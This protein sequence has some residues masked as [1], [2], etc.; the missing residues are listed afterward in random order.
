MSNQKVLNVGDVYCIYEDDLDL[1]WV[2]SDYGLYMMDF[3]NW[4]FCIEFEEGGEKSLVPYYVFKDLFDAGLLWKQGNEKI[5]EKLRKI[6]EKRK[7][8]I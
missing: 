4:E 8:L 3:G 1:D 7:Q 6:A 2:V 5:A